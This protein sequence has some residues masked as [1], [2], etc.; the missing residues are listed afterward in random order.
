[1]VALVIDDNATA[2]LEKLSQELGPELGRKA[3]QAAEEL[4]GLIRREV[5][6]TFNVR[7]GNLARSFKAK[8][9]QDEGGDV[10]VGAFSDSVYAD[11]QDRG[12]TIVPSR[13][14]FLAVP[15]PGAPV[16]LGKWPRDFPKGDLSLIPRRGKRSLLARVKKGGGFQPMFVLVERVKIRGR[17]YI[18]AAARKAE[19]EMADIF[20]DAVDLA[21]ERGF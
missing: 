14:K 7:T 15:F 17:G 20:G 16:P 6:D 18:E 13:R 21:I 8:V 19:P 11:I 4:A 12:G 10:I 9:I 1:M 5:F 3:L 2:A